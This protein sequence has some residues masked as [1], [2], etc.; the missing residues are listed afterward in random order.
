[1]PH[2]PTQKQLLALAVPNTLAAL[3]VPAAELVSLG[4]L[5]HLNDV[6]QLSGVVLA[7][8]IFD[9]IFWCFAFLR[10]G[11]TGLVAQAVGRD[12]NAE[13]ASLFW[14]GMVLALG[15]GGM[16][17]ALQLPIGWLSFN[18]L[19]GDTEMKSAAR[20]YFSAHIWGAIPTL[21]NY[22]CIGWLLGKQRAREVFLI[23][24]VWQG[25]NITLDY[26]FIWKLGMGAEGAGYAIM[27]SEWA[28]M[29]AS[30]FFVYRV[31]GGIPTVDSAQI[32]NWPRLKQLLVLNS[33]ILLRTFL[34]IT[35]LSSFTNI[36]A[37]FGATL[38]A[39]NAI[40]MRL[41]LTYAFLIDGFAV[42][43][44]TMGAT[45]YA[46]GNHKAFQRSYRL[47]VQWNIAVTF[48]IMALYGLG[49]SWIFPL[50]TQHAPIIDEAQHYVGWL[51]IALIGGG[52]AFLYDGFFFG[53][54]RAGMLLRSMLVACAIYLP[55][56]FIAYQQQSLHW[57]WA[58]MLAFIATRVA[59]LH[60]PAWRILYR[61]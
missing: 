3:A 12:D 53:L 54:A 22:V 25:V 40:L 7:T 57:L 32:F 17:L 42:A 4:F 55:F 59:T 38:L 35:V 30:L 15:F 10:M 16:L 14:R 46:A 48:G 34:L 20:I 29:L 36:A 18:L 51:L 45:Y 1:M 39:A 21:I 23:S 13:Q 58:G 9:Y 19:A 24:L 43:L 47:V 61:S 8:V 2:E 6:N 33:A 27:L 49:S 44:E 50:L 28:G 41:W 5:G 26:W 31:W 52:F 60:F 37:G 56:A 11:T